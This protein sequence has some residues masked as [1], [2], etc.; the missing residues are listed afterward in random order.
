MQKGKHNNHATVSQDIKDRMRQHISQFTVHESHYS[1]SK[2]IHGLF[3][4]NVSNV[5]FVP[6]ENHNLNK[7]TAKHWLYQQIFTQEFN[8]VFGYLHSDKQQV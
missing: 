5:R 3:L 6:K 8:T 7:E 4:E 1:Q 2:Q